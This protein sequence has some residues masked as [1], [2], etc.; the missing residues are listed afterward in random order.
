MRVQLDLPRQ[1]KHNQILLA[2]RVERFTQ[3]IQ[4]LEEKLEAVDESP[5]GAERE[6]G[7][8]VFERDEVADVE[9]GRV[10]EVRGGWVEVHVE[11][12]AAGVF[13]MREERGAEGG[14]ARARG[15]QDQDAEFRH[16]D[17]KC[18]DSGLEVSS[19]DVKRCIGFFVPESALIT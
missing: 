17:G 4:V 5:V 16:A 6:L 2:Q 9:V 15:A 1:V 19:S 7:H 12:G 14:F 13:E 18:V 11:G 10:G 8:G 3:K